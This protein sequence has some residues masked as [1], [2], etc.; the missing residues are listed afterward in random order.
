[1]RPYNVIFSIH[2]QGMQNAHIA[3]D[4]PSLPF[5][6]PPSPSL[7]PCFPWRADSRMTDSNRTCCQWESEDSRR[8]SEMQGIIS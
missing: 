8:R 2:T 4:T 3:K 5:S 6:S 1:M 7:L